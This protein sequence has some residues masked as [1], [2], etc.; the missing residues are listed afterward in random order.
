[1]DSRDA[2]LEQQPTNLSSEF[3][4]IAKYFKD[5][6]G[7]RGVELGIG[8]DA[9]LL[10]PEP[11][12]QIV[13]ATDTLVETVHFPPSAS[14]EQIAS[15]ALCVNLSDMAA[16][17]AKPRWFTLALTIPKHLAS[18][19]WLQGF[20]RGLAEISAQFDVAL[21]GGDTTAGPLCISITMI[22]DVPAGEALQRSGAQVGDAIYVT[23]ELADGA[24]ALQA[25]TNPKS[26]LHNSERLLTRFYRPQPQIELGIK[27][28]GIASACIDISDGL[29]ADLGHICAASSVNAQLS[30]ALIPVH[31]EVSENYPQNYLRWALSGGDDYQLC[32]TVPQ[33]RRP[34]IDELIAESGLTATLVGQI[35]AC[36]VRHELVEIDGEI[37]SPNN[38]GFDHFS[39]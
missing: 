25:I 31:R 29:V 1:M 15:R 8:D 20:S 16:M 23:G 37:L 5:L 22:G 17:G 7:Q 9:A 35:V 11:G 34:V 39:S 18:K 30:G 14:A 32:F 28:R 3:S 10:V 38:R 21:V 33:V 27:L 13:V 4:L 36:K 12:R 26:P 24:A 19:Q 2:Q 6:T